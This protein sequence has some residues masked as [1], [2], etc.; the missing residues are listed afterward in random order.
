MDWNELP[1]ISNK[2]DA[3]KEVYRHIGKID[4]SK[5]IKK[6]LPLYTFSKMSEEERLA[7]KETIQ[8]VGGM[9]IQKKIK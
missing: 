2:F 9:R 4:S 3:N 7:P 5:A 8:T 6:Q 1:N